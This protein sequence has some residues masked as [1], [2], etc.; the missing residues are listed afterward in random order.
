MRSL[1]TKLNIEEV[2][3]EV[4]TGSDGWIETDGPLL[5]LV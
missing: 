3:A 4:Y 5:D 1:L 2:N